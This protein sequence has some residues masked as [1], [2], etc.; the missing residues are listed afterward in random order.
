M[1]YF[2]IKNLVRLNR[3]QQQQHHHNEDLFIDDEMINKIHPLDYRIEADYDN[4][5]DNDIIPETKIKETIIKSD[6]SC[7]LN[8]RKIDPRLFTIHFND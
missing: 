2:G 3:K 7:S 5:T 8:K 1:Y 6:A 4:D